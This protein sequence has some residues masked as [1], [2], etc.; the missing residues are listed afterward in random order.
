MPPIVLQMGLSRP[1]ALPRWL[2]TRPPPGSCLGPAAP[3]WV[4]GM[5]AAPPVAETGLEQDELVLRG[6]ADVPLESS[7]A[8]HGALGSAAPPH[9]VEPPLTAGKGAGRVTP[10]LRERPGETTPHN[11]CITGFLQ[12][13]ELPS[14]I[15]NDS[16]LRAP[17]ASCRWDRDAVIPA[18]GPELW[19]LGS[20][21][22]LMAS[23]A[24]AESLCVAA[25]YNAGINKGVNNKPVER[26]MEKQPWFPLG[27][28]VSLGPQESP[29]APAV[30]L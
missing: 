2:S 23:D 7:W 11:I 19:A 26:R 29:D 22:L 21:L 6:S 1:E 3:P 9:T 18:S 16:R 17:G 15:L 5:S 10:R 27:C 4:V 13:W 14:S 20:L 30:S 24:T 12:R 25:S 28:R 8:V